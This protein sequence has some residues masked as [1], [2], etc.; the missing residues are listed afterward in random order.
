VGVLSLSGGCGPTP[1]AGVVPAVVL[2][3][4]AGVLVVPV[5][6][7]TE[8]T[9]RAERL[10]GVTEYFTKPLPTSNRVGGGGGRPR[11]ARAE[12][13]GERRWGLGDA[14]AVGLCRAAGGDGIGAGAVPVE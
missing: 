11:S 1:S 5:V 2:V 3:V 14:A 12:D 4:P 8:G 6:L 9:H 7:G 10:V 13:P